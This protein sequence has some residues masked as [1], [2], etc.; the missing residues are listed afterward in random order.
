MNSEAVLGRANYE[1]T[2]IE[3]TDPPARAR[4]IIGLPKQFPETM[5]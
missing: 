2:S 3:P 4:R 5:P 1:V